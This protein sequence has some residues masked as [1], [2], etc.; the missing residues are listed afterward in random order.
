MLDRPSK[1]IMEHVRLFD[2]EKL[3]NR[4]SV[5]ILNMFK[6]WRFLN[7]EYRTIVYFKT[8]SVLFS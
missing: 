7:L 3:S 6:N 2:S 5:E 4:R 1:P 8:N